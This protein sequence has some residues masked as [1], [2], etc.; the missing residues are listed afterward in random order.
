MTYEPWFPLL[1]AAADLFIYV[2]VSASVMA[3]YTDRQPALP[4]VLLQP[5]ARRSRWFAVVEIVI[6]GLF[7]VPNELVMFAFLT[8]PAQPI[9]T[10]VIALGQ[11]VA[12]GLWTFYLIRLMRGRA[13]ET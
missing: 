12:F 7:L 4:A 10:R 8:F 9:I 6:V 2:L 5:V 1:L 3:R 11:F 13:G